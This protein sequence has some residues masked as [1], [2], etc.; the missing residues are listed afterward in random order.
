[1]KG[2]RSAG[3]TLVEVV[4]ALTVLSLISLATVTALRTFAVTQQ[5][6]GDVSERTA[7][8]RISGQFL[9]RTLSDAMLMTRTSD[10]GAVSYFSGSQDEMIWVAPFS[11]SR[12]VGGVMVFKLSVNYHRE[13]VIQIAPYRSPQQAIAWESLAEYVVVQ[14]LNKFS[15]G[16]LDGASGEWLDNWS[17]QL[18]NPDRVRISIAA[19]GRYW[20]DN[21][22][23]LNESNETTH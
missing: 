22:I 21:I 12:A 14:Q 18:H 16:Y 23:R 20:P 2:R 11:A 6:L 8:M 9:R 5:R 4:V 19:N 15:V 7:D 10:R 17:G 1:M 3:F 13:L